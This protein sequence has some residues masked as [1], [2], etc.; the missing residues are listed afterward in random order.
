MGNEQ[1][2]KQKKPLISQDRA[3]A[4]FLFV[5]LLLVSLIFIGRLFSLQI[6]GGGEFRAGAYAQRRAKKED[7]AQRGSL[8]DRY[9]TPLAL[10]VQVRSAYLSTRNIPKE[11][12]QE[13]SDSLSYIL[14]IEPSRIR[15]LLQSKRAYVRLKNKLSEEEIQAIKNSGIREISIENETERFYPNGPLLSQT[16]GFLSEEGVGLY[17]AEKSFDALL[18]GHSGLSIYTKDLRGGIIPTEAGKHYES[19]NG[20]NIRLTIDLEA[21]KILQEELTRSL[22]KYPADYIMGVM[23]DPNNGEILAM[24]SLPHFDPNQP[25]FPSDVGEQLKWDA[26]SEKDKLERLYSLWI[27]PIVSKLYEPGSVFKTITASIAVENRAMEGPQDHVFCKGKIQIAPNTII[28]CHGGQQHGEETLEEALVNSCNPGFVQVAWKIGP[29]RFYSFLQAFLFGQ[30]SGVDLPSEVA[31]VLPK[32]LSDLGQARF[33]TMAY[34]H[35]I[36]VTPLQ[37][38]SAAN[39]VINGGYFYTP[40]IFLQS[41]SEDHKPLSNYQV[42]KK[43]RIL[44]EESSKTMRAY[45]HAAAPKPFDR[46]GEEE[47]GGKSGTSLIAE[48]GAYTRDVAASY[49]AFFPVEKPRYSVLVVSY[50]PVN[51]GYGVQVA[52]PAATETLRRYVSEVEGLRKKSDLA[53]RPMPDLCGKTVGEARSGGLSLSLYGAMTEYSII[54]EQKPKAGVLTP[55]D[56]TVQVYPDAAASFRVPDLRG[57]DKKALDQIMAGLG[58]AY[59]CKGQGRV[60]SQ[61][62]TPGTKVPGQ[63]RLRFTLE[64]EKKEESTHASGNH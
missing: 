19:Q 42:E 7:K 24:E 3:R 36:S 4:Y 44:S 63:T 16:L 35:G 40:H 45:L 15:E 29:E 1:S 55:A 30:K 10:S 18:R 28:S 2:K 64:E 47:M 54:A 8:F 14:G 60:V 11:R 31:S 51:R 58:Y 34:G 6:I 46:I 26:M 13:I 33:A 57:K 41:L 17:G 62:P 12:Y 56:A 49:F 25:R 23:M 50:R 5:L 38:L 21:Q 32:K 48:Q 59:D 43:D 20:Q 9:Q 39:A 27:N 53:G 22:E 37:M 61:S 52:G